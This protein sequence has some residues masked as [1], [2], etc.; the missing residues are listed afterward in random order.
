MS[1]P[2]DQ[3]LFPLRVIHLDIG[4]TVEL[5]DL[6]DVA[7]YLEFYDSDDPEDSKDVLVLDREGRRVRVV[8][9]ELEVKRFELYDEP[10]L[11]EEEISRIMEEARRAYEEEQ[12]ARREAWERS[13]LYRFL[14]WLRGKR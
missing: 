4:E 8:V 6:D 10:P 3:P 7:T 5:N 2:K 14:R 9:D 1:Q 12:R 11:S 13:I